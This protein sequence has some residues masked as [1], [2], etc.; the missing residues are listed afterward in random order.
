MADF[1]LQEIDDK[2]FQEEGSGLL[3][4]TQVGVIAISAKA[5]IFKTV[6]VSEE[7]GDTGAQSPSATGEDYNEWTNPTNAYVLDGDVASTGIPLGG[8]DFYQD[9]YNFGLVPTGTIVGIE[10]SLDAKWVNY[11]TNS[12][13]EV[14]LSW[15]G[16]D[17]YTSTGKTT[18]NLTASIENYLLGGASDL[19]GRAWSADDVNNANFR[20]RIHN[21]G[22]KGLSNAGVDH[23]TVTIYY[24]TLS[25]VLAKA[26]IIIERETTVT[27]KA[28]IEITT[29]TSATSKANLKNTIVSSISAKSRIG[30]ISAQTATAKANIKITTVTD[31]SAKASIFVSQEIEVTAKARIEKSVATNIS[32]IASISATQEITVTAKA[33]LKNAV[34]TLI[35]AKARIQTGGISTLIIA[36]ARVEK[37]VAT[38]V[39]AK[40][41]IFVSQSTSVI[42]KAR[43]E[44]LSATTLTAKARVEKAVSTFIIA[45]ANLK[46]TTVGNISTK[47]RVEKTVVTSISAKSRINIIS[48]RIITAK[49]SI[50]VSQATS[51]TAKANV[52][53]DRTAYPWQRKVWHDGTR[54]WRASFQPSIP[55][56]I[57]EYSTDCISWTE[58]TNARITDAGVSS[59]FSVKGNADTVLIV[60]SDGEDI[61]GRRNASS[62]PAINFSWKN[63]GLSFDG[64][65]DG[66]VYSF[67]DLSKG[68]GESKYTAI[69]TLKKT[70]GDDYSLHSRRRSV[71]NRIPLVAD[72]DEILVADQSDIVYGSINAVDNATTGAVIVVWQKGIAIESDYRNGID[73]AVDWDG[74]ISIATGKVGLE[75][76]FCV[77]HDAEDAQTC[78]IYIKSDGTPC[79]KDRNGG[80]GNPWGSEEVLDDDTGCRFPVL[81]EHGVN[82][83]HLLWLDSENII[84]ER[85]E[86][87]STDIWTPPLENDPTDRGTV[88]GAKWFTISNRTPGNV[89]IYQIPAGTLACLIV[90]DNVAPTKPTALEAE[91]QTNPFGVVDLTPE[92][93]AL[94]HDVDVGDE[95]IAYHLQVRSDGESF[96]EVFQLTDLENIV[97]S[98]VNY[99]GSGLIEVIGV[100]DANPLGGSYDG[101]SFVDGDVFSQDRTIKLIFTDVTCDA[102]STLTLTFDTGQTLVIYLPAIT[103]DG[104]LFV[105]DDGSTWENAGL[106]ELAYANPATQWAGTEAY[107][108]ATV[109]D[110]ERCETIVYDGLPL[111]LDGS[112]YYWRIRIEDSFHVMSPWSDESAS[113]QMAS[114][115]TVTAKA[116]ILATIPTTVTTKANIKN[117]IATSVQAKARIGLI[118]SKII[119]AKASIFVSQ[120]TLI[121]SKANVLATIISNISGKARVLVGGVSALITGKANIKAT[122]ETDILAKASIFVSQDTLIT[123][124]A[125]VEQ[126][127]ATDISAK[128][129]LESSVNNPILA[130][131]DIK[132]LGVINS[133]T[134]KA[135]IRNTISTLI[136]AKARLAFTVPQNITAK[137]RIENTEGIGISAIANIKNAVST[138]ISGIANIKVTTETNISA[139]ANLRATIISSILAKAR[140]ETPGNLKNVT[141][142]ASIFVVQ[143]T[144]ISAKASVQRT[145]ETNILGKARIQTGGVATLITAKASIFKLALSTIAGKA[146][147]ALISSRI[148][149][150]KAS[151]F[152]TSSSIISAKASIFVSQSTNILV[153][154]NIKVTSDTDIS[155]KA[156]IK[157]TTISSIQAKANLVGVLLKSI[158]AKAN[159]LNTQVTNISAKA[160]I[161]LISDTAILAKASIK[162]TTVSNIQA[163]ANLVGVLL[164]SI[165]AKANILVTQSATILS[166]ARIEAIGITDISAKARLLETSMES[167]S[168][169]ASISLTFDVIISAKA[170]IE[171]TTIT[172]I[173]AKAKIETTELDNIQAKA[174]IKVFDVEKTV[175][176]K[177]SIFVEQEIT[178]SAKSN[179]YLPICSI[180]IPLR[181]LNTKVDIKRK[182]TSKNSTGGLVQTLTTNQASMPATIQSLTGDEIASLQGKVYNYTHR[183][184][185]PKAV[186]ISGVKVLISVREGDM[187]YDTETEV[188]YRV[189]G[190][191]DMRPANNAYSGL[192]YHHYE[193]LL[194]KI[195]DARYS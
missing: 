32:G 188:S 157:K 58:N 122:I 9:Y 187:I 56:I 83:A 78:I 27:A 179:I 108:V 68:G 22:A 153:K 147:V 130:K 77:Y 194:E 41:S 140:I 10:V 23:I 99:G 79:E 16:G 175:T 43:I 91:A 62:Y 116:N 182:T 26:S 134:S 74:P 59:D 176:T 21:F 178:I 76:G 11:G 54:F 136:S 1:L 38:L 63:S 149:S 25:G 124:K 75:Y 185:M 47:A 33:N 170:R 189:R 13:I 169:K 95:G 34:S 172:D 15:D 8:D 36:K 138:N 60:Y 46:V 167:I 18:G 135:N 161:E 162:K 129:S 67:P 128:A 107:F 114:Q 180:G 49:A 151:I 177:A 120:D 65:A 103:E 168:A 39:T 125:R 104:F 155:G 171:A 72:T 156:S 150:A 12:T 100:G 159:V 7:V 4:E 98:G 69:A 133:V 152:K 184:F 92:F 80:S 52:L 24:L 6:V 137:A 110:G 154:A 96:P 87:H 191:E 112:I 102:G 119:S 51:V 164:K 85:S 53:I 131:A 48:A 132:N 145:V 141:A 121:T 44:I 29:S 31:I 127:V 142:K 148:I 144:D 20:A 163:K 146:R 143:T 190:I 61:L 89:L 30:L 64:S 118:N 166:K 50:F 117:T 45:K 28:N 192:K 2:V 158:L 105:T 37:T 42:A 123:A 55:A 14:E 106:D 165:L 86:D 139:K 57:F 88:I 17:T 3:L 109:A 115:I 35:T 19:W 73:N 90:E 183:G 111:S 40:A 93:T 94:F 71:S 160:R 193:L 195:N 84:R 97:S 126:T 113:F 181:M 186:S 70:I 66:G 5:D 82:E 101:N 173:S 174:S 81:G